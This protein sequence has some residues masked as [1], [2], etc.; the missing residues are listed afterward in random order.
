ML[1]RRI[2]SSSLFVLGAALAATACHDGRNDTRMQKTASSAT[3]FSEQYS[4]GQELFEANCAKCHGD[5]GQGSEKA[6]R[7]VGLKEGA[8]PVEPP[9]ERK[10]RKTRFVTVG[11]VADFVVHNMPPNKAGSLTDDEYWAI[12]AFDLHANGIDLDHKL[13]AESARTLTIPR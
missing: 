12:L 10:F 6:P 9:P 5:S 7:I 2:L 8:L 4:A 11:D 3:T 13:Y 1:Q